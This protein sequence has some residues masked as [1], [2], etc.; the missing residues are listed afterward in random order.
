MSDDRFSLDLE[1]PILPNVGLGGIPLRERVAN[2]QDIF[3][4][5]WGEHAQLT[6][7]ALV[8]PFE[9]RYDFLA[10][11]IRAYVD[12]RNGKIFML[13]AGE[14]YRGTLFDRVRV[15]INAG[16]AMNMDH[17][18]YYDEGEATVFCRDAVGVSINLSH[19]DPLPEMVPALRISYINV[20]AEE[21]RRLD[22]QNGRW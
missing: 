9:A 14:G 11:A 12:V 18:L 8:S 10:G 22:A 16:T 17:R 21:T 6:Y 13:S 15:G 7:F 5:R 1:A 20:Y 3:A 2:A 4:D 19:D